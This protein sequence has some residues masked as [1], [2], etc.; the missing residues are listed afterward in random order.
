MAGHELAAEDAPPRTEPRFWLRQCNGA[1]PGELVGLLDADW[2]AQQLHVVGTLEGGLSWTVQPTQDPQQPAREFTLTP[3]TD[4]QAA[5]WI[6]KHR[7]T[8]R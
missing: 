4:A 7:P 2:C 6:R 1:Q 3:L 5:A 8:T